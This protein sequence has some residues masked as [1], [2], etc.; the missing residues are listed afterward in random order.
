MVSCLQCWRGKF[1]GGIFFDAGEIDQFLYVTAP[2]I[3]GS[4]IGP[5][6]GKEKGLMKEAQSL[7]DITAAMVG[8]DIVVNG[9]REKY[10][11]EM[12]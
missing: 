12:M 6:S 3:I 5:L 9:Y 11:F 10:N 1:A 8:P 4:G 7:H 2:K